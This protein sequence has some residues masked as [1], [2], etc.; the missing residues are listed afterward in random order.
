M[1]TLIGIGLFLIVPLYA[2]LGVGL[3]WA[4]GCGIKDLIKEKTPWR[5]KLLRPEV[6]FGTLIALSLIGLFV[7]WKGMELERKTGDAKPSFSYAS[8]NFYLNSQL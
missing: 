6:I 2:F 1:N 3:V 5:V 7:Y 8:A 4:T